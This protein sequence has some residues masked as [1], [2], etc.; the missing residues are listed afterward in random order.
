[1]SNWA[2]SFSFYW[3]REMRYRT[4]DG[5]VRSQDDADIM[6]IDMT[7]HTLIVIRS[8]GNQRNCTENTKESLKIKSWG[9]AALR[10]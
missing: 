9:V 5:K 6:M 10:N 2:I 4:N 8:N 7:D 1:M 3:D